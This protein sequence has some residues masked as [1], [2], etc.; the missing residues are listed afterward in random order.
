MKNA[1]PG[2]EIRESVFVW[3]RISGQ[4]FFAE[5]DALGHFRDRA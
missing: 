2:L 4:R 3:G 5:L 1:L